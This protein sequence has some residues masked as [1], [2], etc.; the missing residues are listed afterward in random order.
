MRVTFVSV[1]RV[2]FMSGYK[3]RGCILY[4]HVEVELQLY[5]RSNFMANILYEYPSIYP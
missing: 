5:M 2:L 1:H 3:P 4:D